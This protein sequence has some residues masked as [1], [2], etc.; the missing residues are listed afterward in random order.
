MAN[1]FNKLNEETK[2]FE[3]GFTIIDNNDELK[4]LLLKEDGYCFN[5]IDITSSQKIRVNIKDVG[6][7]LVY[8]DL[9][10]VDKNYRKEVFNQI[11]ALKDI[12]VLE[13]R[14]YLDNKM[15]SLFRCLSQLN[16]YLVV[17]VSNKQYDDLEEILSRIN[18]E[19]NYVALCVEDII[20]EVVEVTSEEERVK[21]ANDEEYKNAPFM[22][23][24][25]M[26]AL[27]SLKDIVKMRFN[28]SFSA[29]FF[30]L[31]SLCLLLIVIYISNKSIG[32]GVLF[33]VFV[34]LF[35]GLN[36]YNLALFKKEKGK[37]ALFDYIYF[38]LLGFVGVAFGQ[39]FGYLMAKAMIKFENP[40]NFKQNITTA[41]LIA[42]LIVVV[43]LVMAYVVQLL[44]PIIAP[45]IKKIFKK[46]D[47]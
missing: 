25:G 47:K 22:K 11:I 43:F 42:V 23:K 12:N 17:L 8:L 32:L 30:L 29:L 6:Y 24:C 2:S 39:L 13:S 10:A 18:S 41:T 7:V 20:E 45:K 46:E 21:E 40:I 15:T 37:I 1:I 3:N 31:I 26:L 9:N 16:P 19:L 4:P 34:L 33:I 44:I 27:A 28:H 35:I 14:E 36:T 38:G 5:D